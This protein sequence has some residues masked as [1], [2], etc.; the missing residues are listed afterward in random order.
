MG[1][2]L[3]S[4]HF[5]VLSYL[6]IGHQKLGN[7]QRTR[8]YVPARNFWA[9]LTARLTRG[10]QHGEWPQPPGIAIGDY[11]AMGTLVTEQIAFSYFYPTDRDG[12]PLYPDLTPQGLR[13]GASGM[14]PD[15]FAWRYLGSYASTA[16]NY[17]TNSAE[18]GTLH[19]VEF[20][21]SQTRV[22]GAVESY[23]VYLAGYVLVT[24]DCTLPWQEALH[25]IQIGGE[26]GYGWG[27]LRLEPD[28]LVSVDYRSV[29]LFGRM[30]CRCEGGVRPKTCISPGQPLLS[31]AKVGGVQA[32]GD[33]EPV[34]GRAWDNE[35]GAGQVISTAKVCYAPGARLEGSQPLWFEWTTAHVWRA[36]GT[37]DG[38]LISSSAGSG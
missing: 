13:F 20:I 37:C 35:A 2:T 34:V 6:H 16:L 8:S 25:E 29:E 21:A 4:A 5:R 22:D 17:S 18:E 24:D 7:I 12:W 26:R 36:V 27:R 9:F 23:P 15:V 33:I 19:E 28:G 31:H 14:T 11:E 10:A 3:Y 32:A 30:K 1:W 38:R